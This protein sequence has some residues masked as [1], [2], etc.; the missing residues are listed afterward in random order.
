MCYIGTTQPKT[1][2]SREA[3]NFCERLYRGREKKISTQFLQKQKKQLVDLQEHFERYCNVLAVFGFNGRKYDNNNP[4][5]S[6][7]L[8]ILVNERVI[9]PTVIRK[10]NQVVP[11]N[12]GDI[13]SVHIMN[14]FGG[15]TSLDTFLRAYK[16]QTIFSLRMIRLSREIEQQMASP[17]DS[18]LALCTKGTRLK[19]ITVTLKT[20][21]TVV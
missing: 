6:Y 8:P 7:L 16:R 14:T 20:L 11:F 21:L 17:Y 18:F 15:A 9:E 4:I 13:K 3:A 1:Q 19:K 2:P 10:A 12:F 5:K